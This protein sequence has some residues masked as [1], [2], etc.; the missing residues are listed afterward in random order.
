MTNYEQPEE[1]EWVQPVRKGYLMKCCDCGLIHRM[2]FR[3]QKRH[4]QFRVYR[5]DEM[6]KKARMRTGPYAFIKD[7]LAV[8]GIDEKFRDATQKLLDKYV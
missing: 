4:I 3:V 5:E 8:G 6:T 1:G 7:L 2:D